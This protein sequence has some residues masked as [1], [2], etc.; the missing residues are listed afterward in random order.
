[1][2]VA[3]QDSADNSTF[4]AVTGLTFTAV[5]AAPAWQ[6]LATTGNAT[7]RRYVRAV[8]T[9]TFSG[10]TFAVVLDRNL[11]STSF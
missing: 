4:T 6:R 2:T 5:T 11:N 9:G 8:T 3:V 10:A 1:V 7:L